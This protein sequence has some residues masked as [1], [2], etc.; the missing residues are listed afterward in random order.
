[1]DQNIA[2]K[3]RSAH[4]PKELRRRVLAKAQANRS[5]DR[6]IQLLRIPAALTAC[7]ALV[8][9]VLLALPDG[10]LQVSLNGAAITA[11]PAAVS[12]AE[13]RFAAEGE[14][15]EAEFIFEMK[16]RTDFSVS[17]GTAQWQQDSGKAK[18]VW[19]ILCPTEDAECVLRLN[20]EGDTVTITLSY[21]AADG[22]WTVC[23]T[24]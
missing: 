21:S 22:I 23:G 1:M 16:E 20:P 2:E 8:L 3:Y 6:Q 18:L 4:A 13:P 11:K 24:K 15:M 12:V 17:C 19:K 5:A 10:R 7:A 14:P 9:A